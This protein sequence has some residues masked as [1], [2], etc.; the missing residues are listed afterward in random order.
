MKHPK[1]RLERRVGRSL[2]ISRRKQTQLSQYTSRNWNFDDIPYRSR[3][4]SSPC[5]WWYSAPPHEGQ[6]YHY[7]RYQKYLAWQQMSE[8]ER[9]VIEVEALL[10]NQ[11]FEEPKWETTIWQ[12]GSKS[13]LTCG[14][15]SCRKKGQW[16][17]RKEKRKRRTALDK[18]V[19]DNLKSWAL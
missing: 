18:E 11:E 15:D 7:D 12:K 5:P 10:D 8:E 17:Y 1:D 19:R 16:N 13:N 4:R 14:C 3:P 9:K 6:G 2:F